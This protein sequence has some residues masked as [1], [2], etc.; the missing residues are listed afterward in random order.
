MS[1]ARKIAQ[2]TGLLFISELA[3]KGIAFLLLI[4]IARRLGELGYGAY[5]YAFAFVSLFVALSNLGLDTFLLKELARRKDKAKEI[6]GNAMGLRLATL[7]LS[8]GLAFVLAWGLPASRAVLPI[9][10]LVMVH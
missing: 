10:V 8:Y 6:M 1:H 9:I 7:L 5:S 2:N 4:L 3:N